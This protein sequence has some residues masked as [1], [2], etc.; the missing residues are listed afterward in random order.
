MKYRFLAAGLIVLLSA[1]SSDAD[2]E[3]VEDG[4]TEEENTAVEEEESD[5]ANQEEAAAEGEA[6]EPEEP[7]YYEI[8]DLS[9]ELTDIEEK[10]MR[11]P[12]PY[13]G[14]DFDADAVM[15]E[16]S[17]IDENTSEDEAFQAIL[18]LIHEPYYEDVEQVIAFNPEI[19]VDSETPEEEAPEDELP[20]TSHFSILLDASGSMNARNQSGTRMDEAKEAIEAFVGTLPE[21]STTSL[22]VYGHEG[23]NTNAGKELSCSSTETIYHGETDADA[24]SEV[25]DDVDA[26]G[27]TPIAQA[28]EDS[29]EDI[30]EDA[31]DVI[32]YIV[33]DGIETCGGDPV[34]A[35]EEL[36]DQDIEP[37]I[38]IIGFQVEDDDYQSLIDVAEAG[39]GEFTFVDSKQELED[40]WEEEYRRM[41]DAWDEWK[42]AAMDEVN[43]RSAEL[44][45]QANELKDS[46]MDKSEGEFAN[47][48]VIIDRLVQEEQIESSVRR[49]LWSGF[50]NRKNDI[51]SYGYNTGVVNWSN[52]YN[53]GIDRWREVYHLGN[54]KWSEYYNK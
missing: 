39:N 20:S 45:D 4:A 22:R 10:L 35:A 32:V 29:Q 12:G 15:E 38:N 31:T 51:W 30:P 6:N 44:K 5:E 24:L 19:E 18:N 27:W 17:H 46:I 8:E 21:N 40:Y 13:H 9:R 41:M 1:C 25:L 11:M 42:R 47:A 28:I 54:E 43:E 16:L 33:S 3:V 7:E 37:I 36:V 49:D 26:V 50:Y 23:D 34:K 53:E 48:Q 52:A 14:D 2:Q